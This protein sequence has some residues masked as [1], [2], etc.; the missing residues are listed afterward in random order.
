MNDKLTILAVF[1]L[2]VGLIGNA[3]A[4]KGQAVGDYNMEVGW[5]TEPP[6]AGKKNAIE[7]TITQASSSDKKNAKDNRM[8]HG[9]MDSKTE[10]SKANGSKSTKETKEH[11]R[12]EKA[13][14]ISGLSKTLEVDVMLNGKKTFLK[15][16]EDKKN[17]G[18]YHGVFM[19]DTEGQPLVHVVEKIKKTP[20]EITFHPEKVVLPT[21]K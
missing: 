9:S 11:K 16:V 14:E 12:T 8:D 15:L 21:K 19:P 20:V 7:V 2:S 1:A 18:T 17:K 5:K 4:H 3:Y 10:D 13:T 6:I